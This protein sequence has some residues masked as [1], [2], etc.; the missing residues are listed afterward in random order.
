MQR[1]TSLLALAAMEKRREAKKPVLKGP[2]ALTSHK[3]KTAFNLMQRE[4]LNAKRSRLE[5]LLQQQFIG[6]YGSKQPAS[7]INSFIKSTV[8]DFVYSYDSVAVAESM[9]ESLE[10]QIREITAKMREKVLRQNRGGAKGDAESKEDGGQTQQRRG[11][12]KCGVAAADSFNPA[13]SGDPSW[14]LLNAVLAEE[15]EAKE[16]KKRE[17]AEEA[18][19]TFRLELDKQR[20]MVRQR[21]SVADVEKA[22]AF[23]M[24]KRAKDEYEVEQ[25][26]VREK[27]E[28]VFVVEREL[29]LKQIA[30]NQAIRDK[31]KQ[32]KIMQEKM[33]MARSRRLAEEEQEL[34][35][36]KKEEQKR[37]QDRLVE[38]NEHNKSVKAE[39]LKRQWEYEAKLNK[40]YEEKM[41]REEKAR[42]DAFQARLDALAKSERK[43]AGIFQAKAKQ[44]EAAQTKVMEEIE[45]K[46]LADAEKEA[47]KKE[48]SRQEVER[49][50]VFNLT[51]IERK[52]RLVAEERQRD[53]DMRL[54]LEA[55]SA[56][57]A[58]KERLKMADRKVK[59]NE[60]KAKLDEQV[61]FH[62]KQGSFVKGAGLSDIELN[63]NRS[64]IAKVSSDPALMAKVMQKIQPSP[65]R[66]TSSK[67]M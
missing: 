52:Q 30:D 15:A 66:N 67:F 37:A 38:E 11:S 43:A 33:D 21:K 53:I 60:L 55:D 2:G 44:E 28:R 31:E 17:Q 46:R 40:D 23:E 26:R 51:L 25:H 34:I 18:K 64:I 45:K 10:S 5:S 47:A 24:V 20:D 27:K 41:A 42:N 49:S 4:E 13:N 36:L 61:S 29:R 57:A 6:K 3:D 1:S 9:I 35:R 59:A 14:A 58:E 48:A 54:K 12:G 62:H 63:L 16:L 8:T 32:I 39:A 65:T 56:L 19:K 7:S 50:R 22:S